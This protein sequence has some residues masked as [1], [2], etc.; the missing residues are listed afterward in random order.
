[1]V[2]CPFQLFSLI[3]SRMDYVIRPFSRNEHDG[4]LNYKLECSHAVSVYKSEKE[5]DYRKTE[6]FPNSLA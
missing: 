5:L 3:N 4:F 6:E 1:T 2:S